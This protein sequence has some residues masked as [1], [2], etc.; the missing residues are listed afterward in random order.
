MHYNVRSNWRILICWETVPLSIRARP[1]PSAEALSDVR[2]GPVGEIV[3]PPKDVGFL[4]G[5]SKISGPLYEK[6]FLLPAKMTVVLLS[7]TNRV[8]R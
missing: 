2:E 5:L 3:P 1:Q 4:P 6:D 8:S 7:V